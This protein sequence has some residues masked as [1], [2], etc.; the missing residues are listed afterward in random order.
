MK[1][2][3]LPI[4]E[5]EGAFLAHATSLGGRRL[6]KGHLLTAA[7]IDLARETGFESLIVARLEAG[8]VP[9]DDAADCLAKAITASG[10]LLSSA[11]TGRV[12]FHADT[13]GVFEADRVLV[14]RINSIDPGITL[15]TLDQY[16]PVL[17]GRMIATVKIIPYAVSGASLDEARD[18]MAEQPFLVKPYRPHR[19]GLISTLLPGLKQSTV[20]KTARVLEDRLRPS[21]SEIV[22]KAECEHDAEKLAEAIGGICKRCDMIIIFGASAISDPADVIPEGL[23]IAGGNVERVGMPVDP[24]N[25]LMLGSLDGKPVI[26]A[27]GCSRSPARNGFDFVLERL[28]G[29]IEVTGDDISGMGVGG[30]LMEIG[31]RP[32]PREN[33]DN[34]SGGKP[35]LAAIVL[36][37]GQSRRMGKA[38]KLTLEIDGKPMV[39]YPAEAATDVCDS[40]FLVTGNEHKAVEG[41]L[42]GMAF[43]PVHNPE[44]AD[45]LATSLRAGVS[46]LPADATHAVILLGDMPGIT[47]AHLQTMRD[48]ISDNPPGSIIMA[49]HEGKRGNPV[50]WPRA[51]F[52]AL[53]GVSGDTGARHLLGENSEKIVEVELGEAASIDL[54]TPQAY[55]AWNQRNG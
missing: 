24:G 28:L 4:G 46:A 45:G 30:L 29:G 52:D 43:T 26:G 5:C 41:A 39:R 12:N 21:G 51:Y 9:E 13:N 15:A 48:A 18:L 17:D 34:S 1:F 40:L 55:E 19:T 2:G 7:D 27:P 16:E 31:S 14:D 54:D 20:A 23:R 37:A 42:G 53:K 8:D 50:I 38:N 47:S 10:F 22:V 25:L 32:R 49:T 11:G 3:P 36:A 6:K 35:H 33:M 44:H